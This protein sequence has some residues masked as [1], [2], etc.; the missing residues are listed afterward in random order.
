[1]FVHHS[2]AW[3]GNPGFFNDYEILGIYKQWF[4]GYYE[5]IFCENKI[6]KSHNVLIWY[7]INSIWNNIDTLINNNKE[8]YTIKRII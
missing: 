3:T 4:A 2:Q 6:S 7:N 1:M 5:S 8:K